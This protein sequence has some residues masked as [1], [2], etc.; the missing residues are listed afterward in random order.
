MRYPGWPGLLEHYRK[1]L[2]VGPKTE[3]VTLLEGATPLVPAP[4]LSQWAGGGV[5]LYLKYDG[6]NPTG[7][8][9]DRGM[10]MA[11]TKARRTAPKPSSAPRPGIPPR[12]P[13]RIPP[14]PGFPAS[15]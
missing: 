4:K 15:S 14:A 3:I 13:P 7:S 6:M 1:Y 11:I 9:K 8:F 2:P 10:T 12:R 5:K